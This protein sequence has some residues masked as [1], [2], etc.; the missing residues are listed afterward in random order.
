MFRRPGLIAG[1]VILLLGSAV[2][3]RAEDP[4]RSG[5]SKYRERFPAWSGSSGPVK[6][7]ARMLQSADGTTDVVAT[8]GELDATTVAPGNL[9][10]VLITAT[11]AQGKLVYTKLFLNSSGNGTWRKTLTGLVPGQVFFIQGIVLSK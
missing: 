5:L 6:L 11:N 9:Q 8:T 7:P 10:G 2:S 1:V 4:Y 3:A